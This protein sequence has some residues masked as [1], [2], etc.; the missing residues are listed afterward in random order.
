MVKYLF[1]L[2]SLRAP[3]EEAGLI[4]VVI[5]LACMT[6]YVLPAIRLAEEKY[7][8]EQF[9]LRFKRT[10]A[11]LQRLQDDGVLSGTTGGSQ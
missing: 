6:A 11:E 7:V 4:G 9:D 2:R 5:C 8:S 10:V 1:S 3:A